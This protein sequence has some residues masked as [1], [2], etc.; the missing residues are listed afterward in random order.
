M[1]SKKGIFI[2]TLLGVLLISFA[3]IQKS[4]YKNSSYELRVLSFNIWMGGGSSIEK[5]V[6]VIVK[7][8]ADIVGIQEATR[9]GSN[10]ATAIAD[11]LGWYSHVSNS[12]AT[13]ISKFPIVDTSKSKKGVKIET[14]EGKFVW[15]FNVHLSYCPYQPYQLS[16]IEYCGAPIL[17][18]ASEAIE[19]A[20]Q[21]RGDEV[22]LLINEIKE[23]QKDNWPVFVTGDFNEPS[24]LDWTDNAVKENLCQMKV[25]WPV[26]KNLQLEADMRDS[27]RSFYPDE[28]KNPGHT[29][30]T[31]PET[32]NYEEVHDRIDF[33]LYWGENISVSQSQVIGKSAKFSDIVIENYPSD[34]RAVLSTFSISE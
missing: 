9:K 19:S 32:E 17:S 2:I 1:I 3:C 18:T 11:S 8:G 27:Y 16:G 5:T 12:S 24:W 28:V 33:V 25:E 22:T 6:E 34:H 26:T 31:L 7:S 30:T 21:A 20:W 4:S 14:G 10:T 29:W 15:I 23:A 13:I